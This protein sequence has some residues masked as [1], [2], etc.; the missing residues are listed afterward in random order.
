MDPVSYCFLSKSIQKAGEG[1]REREAARRYEL[2]SLSCCFIQK[3]NTGK[4]REREREE[5]RRLAGSFLL[6]FSLR[7]LIQEEGG[8]QEMRW[9]HFLILLLTKS[10]QEERRGWR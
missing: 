3:I 6:L 8:G 2:D 5:A 1:E 4:E 9:I 7:E 10:T